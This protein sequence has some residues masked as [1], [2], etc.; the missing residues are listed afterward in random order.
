L[1]QA[2]PPL[3]H[4]SCLLDILVNKVG[5]ERLRARGTWALFV[6]AVNEER[7]FACIIQ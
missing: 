2:A 1:R 4:L 7:E 6:D 3:D 5:E